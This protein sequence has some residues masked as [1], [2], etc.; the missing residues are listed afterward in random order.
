MCLKD[1]GVI[2][3]RDT[4]VQ[5]VLNRCD[6]IENINNPIPRS[7]S[8]IKMGHRKGKLLLKFCAQSQV[9]SARNTSTSSI[10]ITSAMRSMKSGFS[11]P[12]RKN[13][14]TP[15]IEMAY[16]KPMIITNTFS[17]NLTSIDRARLPLTKRFDMTPKKLFLLI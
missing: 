12:N 16:T 7:N 6:R 2:F 8:P 3:H 15:S 10:P 13:S 11:A 9:I 4:G 1:S 14:K 5:P 17:K